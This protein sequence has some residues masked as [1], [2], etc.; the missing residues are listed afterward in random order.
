HSSHHPKG[1]ERYRRKL[2]LYGCG[3][4]LNDYEGISGHEEYRPDLTLIYLPELDERGDCTALELLPFRVAG[5]RLNA[6]AN[7][8]AQWLADNLSGK[9]PAE[10]PIVLADAPY[11]PE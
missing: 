7:N 6:A 4:L 5:F 1:I 8:E 2:I 9:S 11:A 10:I 3:D